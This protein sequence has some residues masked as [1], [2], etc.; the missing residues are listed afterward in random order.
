MLEERARPPGYEK[1]GRGEDG[2]AGAPGEAPVRAVRAGACSAR[3]KPD[4]GPRGPSLGSPE[5][6][7]PAARLILDPG[8]QTAGR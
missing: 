6:A 1:R 3:P 8:P 2:A 7:Q 4:R 5:D